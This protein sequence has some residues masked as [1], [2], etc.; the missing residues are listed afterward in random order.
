M[1]KKKYLKKKYKISVKRNFLVLSFLNG[2]SSFLPVTTMKA[3]MGS[4]F[5]LAPQL[6]AKLA[7]L[8]HLKNRSMY[9]HYS[10]F[11]FVGSSSFLQVTM[12]HRIIRPGTVQLVVLG[13]LEGFS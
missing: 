7:V 3:W 10:D 13:R 9:N 5:G 8:E 12:I 6:T 11:F 4:N 2:S 1:Q